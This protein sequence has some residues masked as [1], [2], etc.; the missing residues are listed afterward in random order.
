VLTRP[1]DP[2]KPDAAGDKAGE[3]ADEESSFT[4]RPAEEARRDIFLF[5]L[6]ILN[7]KFF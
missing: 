5:C 2:V 4:F 1:E 7:S 3:F 6:F